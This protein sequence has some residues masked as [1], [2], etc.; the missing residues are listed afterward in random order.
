MAHMA[1]SALRNSTLVL[2]LAALSPATAFSQQVDAEVSSAA[3]AAAA[4]VAYVYVG[5]GKG[6]YLYNAAPNGS[7]SLVSGSPF[8]ITGLALGSNGKYFVSLGTTLLRS[9]P[10]AA[11]GAIKAQAAQINTALYQGADC[12]T[13]FG[14]TLDR[15]G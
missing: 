14:G 9:Y 2:C 7:L 4:P 13:T 8:P 1:S 6:A 3:A 12:G 10:V 5:T 11:N 15:T